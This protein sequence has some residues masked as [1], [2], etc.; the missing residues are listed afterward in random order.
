[1]P[2]EEPPH[3]VAVHAG[4][5]IPGADLIKQF[6]FFVTDAADKSAPAFVC[7]NPF[8]HRL[9]FASEAGTLD[10]QLKQVQALNKNIIPG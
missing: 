4:G 10:A 3:E 8:Q 1:M 7:S 6:F 9:I 2:D 5:R